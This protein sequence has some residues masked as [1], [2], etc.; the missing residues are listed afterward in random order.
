MTKCVK[1]LM[2]PFSSRPLAFLEALREKRVKGRF[3]A[4]RRSFQRQR[5]G[6]KGRKKEKKV[7]VTAGAKAK[8][9]TLSPS[10]Q[11]MLMERL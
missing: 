9:D 7:V 6:L 4:L 3:G 10:L 11:K 2:L 1:A 5:K 8:L